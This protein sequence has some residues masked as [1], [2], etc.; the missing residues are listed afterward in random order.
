MAVVRINDSK[1]LMQPLPR[2]VTEVVIFDLFSP[3]NRVVLP[4]FPS[5]VTK[6]TLRHVLLGGPV[7]LSD[8]LREL[9]LEAVETETPLDSWSYPGSLQHVIVKRSPHLSDLRA[10]T[11]G[12]ISV[13]TWGYRKLI[14]LPEALDELR[15]TNHLSGGTIGITHSPHL[16]KLVLTGAA[17]RAGRSLTLVT[18]QLIPLEEYWPNL[19]VLVIDSP[20]TV[21]ARPLNI[22]R[23]RELT[24]KRANTRGPMAINCPM[25][26]SLTV[27]D[28][29]V[30]D[31]SNPDTTLGQ[32]L[33]NLE[34]VHR[35][36]FP[37]AREWKRLET[38]TITGPS[39]ELP[40]IPK[41]RELN[42]SSSM[43]ANGY[44]VNSLSEYRQA[45]GLSTRSKSARSTA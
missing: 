7:T 24:L 5:T 15:L 1:V 19:E 6:L 17:D 26:E 16:R 40:L 2:D 23:L 22:P 14:Q 44:E 27:D 28:Y 34:L 38:L 32:T 25:L 18:R 9:T 4:Q 31:L 20:A 37:A 12:T 36:A 11:A 29:D 41:L 42:I 21:I 45:W 43:I 33:T 30:M 39:I 8:G 10:I 35:Y 3:F 13:S